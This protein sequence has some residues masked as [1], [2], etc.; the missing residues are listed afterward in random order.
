MEKRDKW[1]EAIRAK[2]EHFEA[3]PDP[4]DWEAI[5]E[6][7]PDKAKV[8]R[9]RTRRWAY[10]T[11][12]AVVSLLLLG[13][14]YR[15]WVQGEQD[16]VIA[17]VQESNVRDIPA[18]PVKPQANK[19]D[20]L[21]STERTDENP[22]STAAHRPLPVRKAKDLTAQ[23][24]DPASKENPESL[25]PTP[26]EN[27][28]A[29]ETT[30]AEK[31]VQEGRTDVVPD[32]RPEDTPAQERVS[33]SLPNHDKQP[34]LA[35]ASPRPSRS[36][37]TKRRWGLGMGGGSLSTSSHSASNGANFFANNLMNS[38]LSAYS[39]RKS[40]PNNEHINKLDVSHKRPISFGLGVSYRLSD[41]WALQSGV[42]YTYMTSTWRT[43][44]IRQ[45]K[46][47]QR[48][49]FVGVPLG[50]DYKIAEWQRVRFYAGAGA[51]VEWNVAGSID[52]DYY[53]GNEMVHTQH[54]SVRMKEW[55]WSVNA[56][57]GA[58]YPLFRYLSAYVE[59]NANYYFDN[60]SSIETIRSE[61]P[62]YVSLQAGVRLGL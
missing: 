21:A 44:A 58:S 39:E 60:R 61:K 50:V 8:I 54:A 55:Q 40:L 57:T 13:G 34:L 19:A 11:A 18:S 16:T 38:E 1:E 62:F 5:S 24:T 51:M 17:E 36:T 22:V 33:E 26:E 53:Y 3:I 15:L 9:M 35:D 12:A 56:R 59:G 23:T 43:E 6:R 30:P 47:K 10:W 52:T 48:L 45:G 37:G 29:L 2:L 42:T 28:K 25:Y 7:L 41:R 32:R 4:G 14:G 31:H 49:H 20:G 46:A 27:E